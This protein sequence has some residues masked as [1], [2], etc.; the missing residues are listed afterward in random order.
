[1]VQ[2]AFCGSQL[3]EESQ[4]GVG[5]SFIRDSEFTHRAFL[6][7]MKPTRVGPAISPF[8]IG[9]QFP[10]PSSMHP[11]DMRDVLLIKK[12]N[13]TPQQHFMYLSFYYK[14]S[15]KQPL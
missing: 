5:F 2:I 11:G 13:K 3:L 12:Q 9:D 6:R 14:V 15:I 10:L 4:C 1:M 8:P 7:Q